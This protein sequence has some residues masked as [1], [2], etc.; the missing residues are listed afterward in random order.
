MLTKYRKKVKGIELELINDAR[1][2]DDRRLKVA[3]TAII[4]S[5]RI[6]EVLICKEEANE[7]KSEMKKL[8]LL[9]RKVD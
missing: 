5:R 2:S 9:L 6:Q 7:Q 3:K 1:H 4:E 8:V